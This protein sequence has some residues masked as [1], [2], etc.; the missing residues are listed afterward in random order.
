MKISV[1]IIAHNEEKYITKC[2]KSILSQIK[3]P[4]EI[5][6]LAHNC[7]DKTLEI[8]KGFPITVVPFNGATGIINARLEGLKHVSGD[9]ILCIDGDSF[10]KNNWVEIMTATLA[11]NKNVLVGSWVKFKGTIF[12]D[13]YNIYSKYLFTSEFSK[14]A[15]WIWGASLAF[16]GKDKN[17]IAEIFKNSFTLSKKINLPRNPD[18]YWLALFMSKHGTLQVTNKTWVQA[19][20][21]NSSSMQEIFRRIESRQN[22][23]K[24]RKYF[25]ANNANSSWLLP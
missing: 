4:D 18:D 15:Y 5:V 23:N 12:G 1:L 17:L 25:I 11:N 8:A 24:M 14:V 21:K 16:W 10:A 22:R 2:I 3:H 9:I 19:S 13:I 6:L 7:T 20:T